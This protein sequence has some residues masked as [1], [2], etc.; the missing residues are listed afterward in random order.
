MVPSIRKK[1]HVK[2]LQENETG[3]RQR[4]FRLLKARQVA[5]EMNTEAF[6]KICTPDSNVWEKFGWKGKKVGEIITQIVDVGFPNF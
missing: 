4:N 6:L 1:N 5:L 2:F 3:S